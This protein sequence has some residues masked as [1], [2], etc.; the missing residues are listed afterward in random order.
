MAKFVGS[1]L[2]DLCLGEYHR[3]GTRGSLLHWGDFFL[4]LLFYICALGYVFFDA[5]PRQ[6]DGYALVVVIVL[7]PAFGILTWAR[8]GLACGYWGDFSSGA[9]VFLVFFIFVWPR[10]HSVHGHAMG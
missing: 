8:S 3:L 4:G 2:F 10:P 7:D 1:L 9:T 6:P 5:Q